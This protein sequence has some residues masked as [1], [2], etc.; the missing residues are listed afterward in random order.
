MVKETLPPPLH[1]LRRLH[2]STPTP[3][4][5]L[6]APTISS[7]CMLAPVLPARFANAGP[8]RHGELMVKPT[9]HPTPHTYRSSTISVLCLWPLFRSMDSGL[10][11]ADAITA[12]SAPPHPHPHPHMLMLPERGAPLTLPLELRK[13][14]APLMLASL[15]APLTI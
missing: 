14:G 10:P 15:L 9:P 13:P 11:S 5:T 6:V 12:S 4:Y 2:P 8:N 7:L 3:R 1:P